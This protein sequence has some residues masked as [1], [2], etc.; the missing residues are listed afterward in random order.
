MSEPKNVTLVV[1]NVRTTIGQVVKH[2]ED[3]LKEEKEGT[4]NG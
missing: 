4:K 1:Q 3:K 2:V